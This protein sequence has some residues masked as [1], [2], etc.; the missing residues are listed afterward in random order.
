[1]L[2]ALIIS[3][4]SAASKG[5]AELIRP[6]HFDVI[7]ST[8]SASDARR[9]LARAD[10]AIVIINT[11]LA[12]EFG[13]ELALDVLEQDGPDVAILVRHEALDDAE[14][15]LQE[16][17]AF[18][19]S[20]P[21]NRQLFTQDIR[22]I[23]NARNRRERLEKQNT[24]LQSKMDALKLTYRAKLTLMVRLNM[25]EDEAHRYLQKKAMDTRRSPGEVAE[26][27]LAMY[28]QD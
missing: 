13:T 26:S 12:H 8:D 16:S 7:D 21:V 4:N 27:I 28:A 5:L 9:R 6:F 24:K 18:V 2:S 17:A 3:K 15:R 19:V 22:F 25:T 10:Y 11:P 1:M 14:I 20:K 23:L